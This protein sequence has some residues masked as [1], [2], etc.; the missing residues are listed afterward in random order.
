[1]LAVDPDCDHLVYATPDLAATLRRFADLTGIKPAEGGQ[2]VGRGTRNYLVGLGGQRYLEII[3]PD[4]EQQPDPG[5]PRPFGIDELTT[6]ELVT[7]AVHP[8]DIEERVAKARAA[9]YD[10][11]SIEPLSRRTPA[12]TLL[13]WRLTQPA[14]GDRIGIVPFL[15]DWGSTDHPSAGDLPAAELLVLAA[16]HPDPAAA[17]AQLAALGVSLDVRAGSEQSLTAAL[18]TPNGWV[19]LT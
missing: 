11:G 10:P 3:G 6:T 17:Q 14:S 4:P 9:G 19:T 15:I 8:V 7:W 5:R 2:H 16:T 18:E 1:M 13:E 12:G